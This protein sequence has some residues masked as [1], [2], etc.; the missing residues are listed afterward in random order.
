MGFSAVKH[1]VSCQFAALIRR[2]CVGKY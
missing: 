1:V 2:G